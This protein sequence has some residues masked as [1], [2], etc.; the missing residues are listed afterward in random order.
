M[1]LSFAFLAF[2]AHG[3]LVVDLV[4]FGVDFPFCFELLFGWTS[5]AAA[6]E[7]GESAAGET[8]VSDCTSSSLNVSS[9]SSESWTLFALSAFSPWFASSYLSSRLCTFVTVD[10]R[11]LMWF[12]NQSKLLNSAGEGTA[13]CPEPDG[14]DFFFSS[15]AHT[16]FGH[17]SIF[18]LLQTR[19]LSYCFPDIHS[20]K[21]ILIVRRKFVVNCRIFLLFFHK[22]WGIYI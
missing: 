12:D 18:F 9:Y 6:E 11:W 3:L 5:L 22:E 10:G 19:R 8:D 4:I 15:I 14:T 13:S 17:S 1:S 21:L 7:D 20:Y 16:R 2:E